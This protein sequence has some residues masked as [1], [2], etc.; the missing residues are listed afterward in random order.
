MGELDWSV[1]A[2]LRR[3]KAETEFLPRLLEIWIDEPQENR[4]LWYWRWQE[5]MVSLESLDGL[6]ISGRLSAEEQEEYRALV[7]ALADV[8]PVVR[9]LGFPT[10]AIPLEI[11]CTGPLPPPSLDAESRAH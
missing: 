11:R 5:Y 7:R 9:R 3:L 6:Y 4:D 8:M 10:P 1:Q 2:N